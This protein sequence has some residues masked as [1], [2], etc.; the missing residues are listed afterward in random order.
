MVCGI[1]LES[2]SKEK[3]K[4]DQLMI[5]IAVDRVE[6][7]TN[8]TPQRFI[9]HSDDRLTLQNIDY[10]L[11]FNPH[12]NRIVEARDGFEMPVSPDEM[13]KI[14]FRFSCMDH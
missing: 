12:D 5:A 14:L 7:D 9:I 13:S 3:K 8:G 4:K 2:T 1:Q 10:N 11:D 6:A